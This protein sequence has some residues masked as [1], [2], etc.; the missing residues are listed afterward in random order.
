MFSSVF[1]STN[2]ARFAAG[3]VFALC[4]VLG[5]LSFMGCKSAPDEPGPLEGTW[6]SDYGDSYV[7]TSTT[8]KY[9]SYE[10]TIKEIVYFTDDQKS[11]VIIYEYIAGKEQKYYDYDDNWNP[12]GDPHYGPGKFHA[13][14]FSEL[15]A[16]T[17]KL[18]GAYSSSENSGHGCEAA[19]LEAA[20]TKFASI[21]ASQV[22]APSYGTYTK[23]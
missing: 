14:Y 18:A 22:Y 7:L 6:V 11:G 15:T 12:V 10:G 16:S 19:T 9:G 1:R 5:S 2:R 3:A 20:K 4:L 17:I 13:T 23:Q 21:D 8:L